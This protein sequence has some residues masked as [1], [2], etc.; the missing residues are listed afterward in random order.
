MTNKLLLKQV[1]EHITTH[2]EEHDALHWGARTACGTTMCIAG[3]TVVMCG[4]DLIWE[5]GPYG[6]D[7]EFCVRDGRTRSVQNAAQ[8]ELGLD[9]LT[10]FE[11]FSP[12]NGLYDVLR[13]AHRIL[14]AED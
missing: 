14:D 11:L 6:T 3:R 1:T 12:R 5:T 9:L 4:W 7:A 10:A 8:D 13:I 2:P